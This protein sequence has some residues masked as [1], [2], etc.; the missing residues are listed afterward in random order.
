MAEIKPQVYKDPRPAEYFTRFHDR[1]RSRRPDWVYELARMV[2]T[3]PSLL[4]YRAAAIGVDN[5]PPSGPVILA[6]NHFSQW[7]HFFTGV[8]LRRKIRFMAKSQLFSNRAIEFIFAH[9][10]VFPVRRGHRDEEAFLTAHTIL[11]NGGCL[12]MYAEGGRSR[13]GRLGEPRP[14]VG[15]LALESGVPVVPVAIHG[16]QG[17]RGWKRLRFP[18]VTVQYGEPMSFE[19][20]E[21]P[22]R[23]QQLEAAQRIFDG[24]RA[25]YVGLEEQGRWAVIKALRKGLPA[26]SPADASARTQSH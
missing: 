3:P 2:L 23:E 21:Q 11:D 5:V 16:S 25:M 15:R 13:T 18:K 20:V 6:P 10:G 9:G 19:V 12:L 17:V 26:G 7:D 14:G 22:T 24:V 8:Y 1:A 4:F